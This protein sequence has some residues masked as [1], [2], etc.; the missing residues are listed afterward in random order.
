MEDKSGSLAFRAARQGA[1]AQFDAAERDI[2]SILNRVGVIL[3][4]FIA[5]MALL[6]WCLA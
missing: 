6:A 4:A 1:D 3:F 5:V 2:D